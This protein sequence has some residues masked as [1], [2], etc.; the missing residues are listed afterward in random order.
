MSVQRSQGRSLLFPSSMAGTRLVV[1][2]L[3][4]LCCFLPRFSLG[5]SK[6]TMI[7]FYIGTYTGG[8][9]QGIYRSEL[10]TENGSMRP[11]T[12]VA[13]I[14]NPSFLAIHPSLNVLYAVSESRQRGDR[15]RSQVIAY[16]IT[17]DGSL[18]ELGG[19]ASGGSGPC[20]VSTDHA[21]K[22]ALVAN[23]GSGSIAAIAINDNGSLGKITC[24]VQHEGSSVDP[25]RQKGPHAHCIVVD[26]SDQYVCAVD[27]G[28]DQIVIYR[29]D[30]ET[31]ELNST[32][33]P[34]K[35][36]PGSGP[37]HVKFHPDGK[38][39][40]VIHEMGN[41]LSSLS[42]DSETGR[43]VELDRVATLPEGSIESNTTAEVLVHPDGKFIYGSNRGH[44]SIAAFAFD[45][46]TGKLTA[47]GHTPTG[48]KTPRNFRID[49]TG[50]YLL[51]ENQ[52]SDDIFAFRIDRR[53]GGLSPIDTGSPIAVGGPCCIKFFHR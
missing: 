20:Y 45:A 43:M 6:E 5:Q 27:L 2:V 13:Q 23:Y 15:K 30:R 21:G 50:T 35:V 47:I 4:A 16:K 14:D 12:L 25:G 44:D 29:L 8:I 18:D 9:S 11:A 33:H 39:A 10:N 37:R 46:T 38:H 31:G 42:W 32:G 24:T 34:L 28:L 53:T 19:Q 1:G 41:A 49:P 52:Q 22:F 26:P 3:L 17:T 40:F 7:P 51:A 48:G 36:K